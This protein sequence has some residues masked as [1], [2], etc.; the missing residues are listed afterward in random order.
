MKGGAEGGRGRRGERRGAGGR[1]SGAHPAGWCPPVGTDGI[2]KVNP[3]PAPLGRTVR[4]AHRLASH[5]IQNKDRWYDCSLWEI[6]VTAEEAGRRPAQHP[7]GGRGWAFW[8]DRRAGRCRPGTSAAADPG[9]RQPVLP[10]LGRGPRGGGRLEGLHAANDRWGRSTADSGA[11]VR[12]GMPNGRRAGHTPRGEC[13]GR[14]SGRHR[15]GGCEPAPT[16]SSGTLGGIA[17]PATVPRAGF[18]EEETASDMI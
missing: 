17:S 3:P 12:P 14:Y 10:S 5:S 11:P 9:P 4:C 16:V 18:M 15:W 13:G 6:E 7:G 1:P 8:G 2:R